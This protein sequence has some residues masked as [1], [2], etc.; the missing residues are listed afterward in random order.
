[1][2]YL[3]AG[4]IIFLGNHSIRIV[5]DDFRTRIIETRG[6]I[7]W[8]VSYSIFSLIGIALI[9]YG[10]GESRAN[11]VFIWNPPL[12]TRHAAALLVLV[13]FILFAAASVPHNH[14]KARLGHPMFAGIKIWAF[15]H[16]LAN[17]RLGDILLF[18]SFM[19]WAV[20][21]FSA[22]RKRD[23]QAGIGWGNAHGGGTVYA[24][25]GGIVAYG[26]FAAGLHRLLIGVPPF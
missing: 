20:V 13:A 14:I 21:G 9:V 16:L 6:K 26:I 17:G 7:F 11:P 24:V 18:A 12:W 3:L 5:A 10:F 23:K 4:L 22:S 2:G 1:M 19:I 25:V 8:R 15:A